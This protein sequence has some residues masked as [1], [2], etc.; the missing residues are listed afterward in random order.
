[1]TQ[2]EEPELDLGLPPSKRKRVSAPAE[3]RVQ[4]R[5]KWTKYAAVN[6]KF[7]DLCFDQMPKV[8]GV[9]RN[10]IPRATYIED[11]PAGRMWLCTV[12]KTERE[13]VHS[14]KDAAKREAA[15]QD[16]RRK[17]KR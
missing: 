11:G 8:N 16:R 4:E 5:Q 6:R 3:H 17:R 1:M 13:A 9:P 14:L 12:H 10:V 7:C 2:H 15:K